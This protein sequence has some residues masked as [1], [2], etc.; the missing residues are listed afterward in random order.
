MKCLML[1]T[2]AFLIVPFLLASSGGEAPLLE[3]ELISPLEHW[4]NH[5]SCSAGMAHSTR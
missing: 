5:A 2:A 3:A 4:H 1:K